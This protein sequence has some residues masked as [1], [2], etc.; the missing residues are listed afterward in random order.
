[1]LYGGGGHAKGVLECLWSAGVL[2]AGFFDDDPAV[3]ELCGIRSLGTF[4]PALASGLPLLIA[5]GD[6]ATRSRVAR[7]LE[8]A[9]TVVSH[10]S[11][12]LSTLAWVDEG[13]VVFHRAVVQSGVRVGRHVI[14]NTAAVVEHDCVLADFVHVAPGAV[15]C[16]R[17]RVDEGT[18]IGA[19]ATVL[20]G[21]AIGRWCTVGAG[22]VVT[23]PLP[24]FSVAVGMPARVIRKIGPVGIRQLP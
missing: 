2:V 5:I 9:S 17:V 15:L 6:N 3:T 4:D 22:A 24:D 7:R 11:A 23:R 19:G 10:S 8:H 1:M 14:L 16:G 21:V 18:L 13:T 12:L 20:P